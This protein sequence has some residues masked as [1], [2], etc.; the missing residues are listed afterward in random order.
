MVATD[1][2]QKGRRFYSRRDLLRKVPLVVAGGIVLGM[3]SG[4]SLLTRLGHR[5]RA[6]KFPKGSIF[7]PAGDPK[8]RL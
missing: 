8:D 1:E 7:T 6:P 3:V 5:R 2:A 4:R